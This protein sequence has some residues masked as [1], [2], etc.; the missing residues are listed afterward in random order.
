MEHEAPIFC[1]VYKAQLGL[2]TNIDLNPGIAIT[3]TR[4]KGDPLSPLALDEG[5]N[6]REVASVIFPALQV[7]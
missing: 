7:P 1:C 6:V 5:G 2:L 3:A 4:G